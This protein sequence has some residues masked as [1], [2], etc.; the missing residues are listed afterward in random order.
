MRYRTD[1]THS[2]KVAPTFKLRP[3]WLTSLLVS[4][5]GV[6]AFL[7]SAQVA[8]AAAKVTSVTPAEGCPGEIVTFHGTG[9]N[10]GAG[11]RPNAE[12]VNENI[13]EV[14]VHEDFAR[15]HGVTD[16]LETKISTEQK[17]VV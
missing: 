5:L 8:F 7:G 16:V 14:F 11:Q 10:T 3:T 6:L 17:A 1:A 9:F 12:W 13:D 2:T 15:E 4:T